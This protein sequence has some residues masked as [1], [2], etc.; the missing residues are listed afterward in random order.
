MMN[1]SSQLFSW[2]LF[3]MT[4][5][6]LCASFYFEYVEG[7]NPCPLCLMQRFC[8]MLTLVST[9]TTVFIRKSTSLRVVLGIQWVL[10]AAGI[11]FSGRQ[12]WLQ[13]FPS[14]QVT[15]CLPG[16]NMMVHYLPWQE[17]VH[18]LLLGGPD[19][20][21]VSWRFLGLTMPGWAFVYFTG[22]FGATYLLR[23][24]ASRR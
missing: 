19:C 20:A 22:I 11:F 3:G 7:L 14:D 16:L 4:L 6:M 1:R 23:K 18:T 24:Y 21:E 9:L 2:I 5:A 13:S 10:A 12:L 8:V 17:I 15:S